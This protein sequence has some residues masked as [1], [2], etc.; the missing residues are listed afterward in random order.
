MYGMEIKAKHWQ[1]E[2]SL[3]LHDRSQSSINIYGVNLT[4]IHVEDKLIECCCTALINPKDYQRID[5]EPLFNFKP[6]IR[7]PLSD[8]EFQAEPAIQIEVSLQ[9]D[10]FSDLIEHTTD[11]QTVATYLH[12]LS[13]EQPDT[14]LLFTENWLLLSVRQSQEFG[15][16][17]YRTL[18]DYLRPSIL[19]QQASFFDADDDADNPV[20]EALL[21]FFQDWSER[22]LSTVAEKAASELSEA[23][24]GMADSFSKFTNLN[25]AE[26][27]QLIEDFQQAVE[28]SPPSLKSI[29][30][31]A[32]AFFTADDWSF[33]KAQGLPVLQLAFQGNHGSWT[34]YAKARE[35][36]QQLLFYSIFPVNVPEG[37]RS[38]VAELLTRANYGLMIGNF[39]LDFSDGEIRYKTSIDV[40]GDRLT[41]ALIKQLVYTNVLTLDQYLPAIQAVLAGEAPEAAMRVIEPSTG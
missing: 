9:P 2:R 35:A 26:F 37:Q 16:V 13:Q 28:S 18:W 31:H 14:P 38:A 41:S 19:A 3:K 20:S 25:L 30:E 8:A 40:T 22:K 10:F 29:L 34:C 7:I 36:E 4:S 17:G 15:E 1:L 11:A 27:T 12:N 39:E 6:E 5:T 21:H 23:F 32:I 24:E 33:T